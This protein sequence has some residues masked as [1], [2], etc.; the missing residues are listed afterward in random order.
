MGA[1]LHP[2]VG[3]AS[4]PGDELSHRGNRSGR[5]GT[6]RAAKLCGVSSCDPDGPGFDMRPRALCF[7]GVS[8]QGAHGQPLGVPTCKGHAPFDFDAY[9]YRDHDGSTHLTLINKSYGDKTHAAAVTIT[10]QGTGAGT[11]QSMDL[12]QKDSDVAAKTGVTLGGAAIDQQ[13]TWAGQWR[14]IDQPSGRSLTIQVPYVTPRCSCDLPPPNDPPEKKGG[15][16]SP[17]QANS[18][19]RS[20]RAWQIFRGA[21]G[22]REASPSCEAKLAPQHPRSP[23][24]ARGPAAPEKI[25]APVPKSHPC[26]PLNP[27]AISFSLQSSIQGMAGI[28]PFAIGKTIWRRLFLIM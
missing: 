5:D 3:G 28:C 19:P 8:R 23:R 12:A 26:F 24:T 10:L 6:V 22:F 1:G 4:H 20:Q 15:E 7:P 9:A 16:V 21:L 27:T 17:K 11:W 25:A 18:W 13:G 2:L 14:P